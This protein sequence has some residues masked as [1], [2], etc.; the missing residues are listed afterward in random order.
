[1]ITPDPLALFFSSA[2]F[3]AGLTLAVMFF[4]FVN[5][6]FANREHGLSQ[7][8]YPGLLFACTLMLL[9]QVILFDA[10][11]GQLRLVL[12][13]SALLINLI[14]FMGANRGFLPGN[15]Y[16]T[17]FNKFSL[18]LVAGADLGYLV[19]LFALPPVWSVY[20]W[21]FLGGLIQVVAASAAG[22]AVAA[23]RG[24]TRHFFAFFL[25]QWLL[26][27][28]FVVLLYLWL[29]AM[30]SLGWLLASILV[31]FTLGLLNISLVLTGLLKENHK[32][33][34]AGTQISSEDLFSYT[35]DPATNLPSYQQ[36]LK[37][38]D[39]MLKQDSN[40]RFAAVVF[41][42][43]NF[44]QVNSVLGHHNSDLLLLQ[45]AYC[46][47]Q[48]A[49][50]NRK[51]VNFDASHQPIRLAR[52]QGLNFLVV[53]ELEPGSHPEKAVIQDLC[54]QLSDA[55]PDAMSFKSFSLN[56]ELAFGVAFAQGHATSAGELIAFA[57]D[58]LLEAEQQ[59]QNLC[60]FDNSTT[61]YT[62]Q[63]LLKMER[64]KQ[65]LMEENL[66]WYL[67]PQIA[68]DDKSIK[69]FELMVHWYCETEVALELH[70]FIDIAEQSGE[71]HLLMK[72]MIQQAFRILAQLQQMEIYRPLSLNIP[73]KELLE[74]ELV[75]FIELQSTSYG[76]D[77][78]Y[79]VVELTEEVMLS[80]SA[81]TKA[82]IDQLKVLE[83]GIAID[84]FSGSYESLRYLRKMAINQ[85][86]IDCSRLNGQEENRADKA[87]INALINLTR[88][89]G[90][91]MTGIGIAS[92]EVEH[93]FVA[94]G[95]EVAQGKVIHRG[96]VPDE[97]AIWLKRWYSQYPQAKENKTE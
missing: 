92:P 52:L 67:Q 36:A 18:I 11:P 77:T 72:N 26:T 86:K 17:S 35:H 43:V 46:I 49:G 78:K 33:Q 19:F 30:L 38:F 71:V 27:C 64:L 80:A 48:K 79:L 59:Q 23:G 45:L 32:E 34:N 87:I 81:R 69:G 14:F 97:L 7:W 4:L 73:S 1:M 20:G 31:I 28:A 55:V 96:V 91:P 22:L 40:R 13:I 44:Q 8:Y 39:R 2:G 88:N 56:F 76:I 12:L 74:S 42:P 61:L 6:E 84:H 29:T 53:A 82:I 85:V 89:M 16:I 83:I 10:D 58:A 65:D 15:S 25:P 24:N 94:M 95:G 51:L 70:E 3:I 9:Y 57:G 60:Y 54:R 47:Q 66:R 63:Q 75:D 68:L 50:D 5:K 90:L 93:M 37:Q 21:L 62:E 41:K